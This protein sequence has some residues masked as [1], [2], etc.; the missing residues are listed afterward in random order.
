MDISNLDNNSNIGSSKLEKKKKKSI[1]QFLFNNL[2]PV[3]ELLK[4]INL[5]RINPKGYLPK[6]EEC[7]KHI[8][9]NPEPKKNQFYIFAQEKVPKIM[10]NSGEVAFRETMS[11]LSKMEPLPEYEYRDDLVIEVPENSKD[12]HLKEEHNSRIANKKKELQAKY[13]SF[14][15]HYDIGTHISNISIVLQVVDDNLGF[16]GM[17]RL[18]LLSTSFKYVGI[19]HAKDKNKHCFYYFF[20]N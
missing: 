13:K 6:I 15:F 17:R 8:I 7:I 4:E 12:W 2:D 14:A 20:A 11:L 16:N 19:G 10:L 1:K 18:N 9:P 5:L 3:E